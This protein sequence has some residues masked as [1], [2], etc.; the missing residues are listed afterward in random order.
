MLSRYQMH[1][2]AGFIDGYLTHHIKDSGFEIGLDDVSEIA[3]DLAGEIMNMI[4]FDKMPMLK[5]SGEDLN[6]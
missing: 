2:I 1:L 6:S 3:S 4:N 5:N